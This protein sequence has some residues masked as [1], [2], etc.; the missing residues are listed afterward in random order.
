MQI[1]VGNKKISSVDFTRSEDAWMIEDASFVLEYFK[2][3]GSIV[4]GGDILTK[5][6]E[7]THD[8]W[9]YNIQSNISPEKNMEISVM[10]VSEY[11]SNYINMNGTSFYVVFVVK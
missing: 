10:T 6:L 3:N 11:I 4:L 8:S 5:N 1:E 7:Y 9:Y 2:N